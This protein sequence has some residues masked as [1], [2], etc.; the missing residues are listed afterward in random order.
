MAGDRRR[1]RQ[2]L[3]HLLRNAVRYTP[4]G[5]RILIRCGEVEGA[6][7]IVISDNGPGIPPGERERIFRRFNRA[8]MDSGPDGKPTL[9]LGLPLTRQFVEAHGGTL[10]LQSE[11]GEGTSIIVRLPLMPQT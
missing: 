2:G 1:L 8:T 9:G 10:E 11:V 7:E 5:G 4:P 6:A 3:D